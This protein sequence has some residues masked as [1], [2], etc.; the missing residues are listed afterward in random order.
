MT[1]LPRRSHRHWTLLLLAAG[2]AGCPSTHTA[3]V[4]STAPAAAPASGSFTVDTCGRGIFAPT[5]TGGRAWFR[6]KGNYSY[7]EPDGATVSVR[8]IKVYGAPGLVA[9][10]KLLAHPLTI[11]PIADLQSPWS[12][13]CQTAWDPAVDTFSMLVKYDYDETVGG[14]KKPHS[15]S[16]WGLFTW[17]EPS[18]RIELKTPGP[19]ENVTGGDTISE[20][21]GGGTF[22][23]STGIAL[24]DVHVEWA[25]TANIIRVY[26]APGNPVPFPADA[27][28]Y[29]G[30]TTSPD[31]ITHN[32]DGVDL[33][34]PYD[35]SSDQYTLYVKISW[36]SGSSGAPWSGAFTG[37][38][39]QQ[40]TTIPLE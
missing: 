1:A 11:D 27:A 30:G 29:I 19:T 21:S 31:N 20:V 37:I 25:G 12:T 26:A 9:A 16:R 34:G 33:Q 28:H 4:V 39:E 24:Y 7:L 22:S 40:A 17:I 36:A 3:P 2:L 32:W 10:N 18:R 15:A 13:S 5:K 35:G 6:L 38:V 14:I 23:G 8:D